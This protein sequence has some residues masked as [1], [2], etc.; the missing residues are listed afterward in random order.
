MKNE[1]YRRAFDNLNVPA[2]MAE[3]IRRAAA[4]EDAKAGEKAPAVLPFSRRKIRRARR[5]AAVRESGRDGVRDGAGCGI[6]GK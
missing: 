1:K 3:R 5:A 4:E 6:G 2:D